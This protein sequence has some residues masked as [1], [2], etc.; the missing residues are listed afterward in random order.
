MLLG[1]C[2]ER[3]STPRKAMLTRWFYIKRFSGPDTAYLNREDTL[4][5]AFYAQCD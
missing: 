4:I 2:P 1:D 5:S 3:F